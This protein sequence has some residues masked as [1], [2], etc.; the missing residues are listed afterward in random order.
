M[1]DQQNDTCDECGDGNA[2]QH[3]EPSDVPPFH[4]P[5]SAVQNTVPQHDNTSVAL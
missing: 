2:E 5:P 3:A 4:I 1:S